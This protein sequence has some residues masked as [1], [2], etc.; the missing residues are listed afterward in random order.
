MLYS[1]G[2]YLASSIG[3]DR[4]KLYLQPRLDPVRY[5]ANIGYI[6]S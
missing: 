2:V 6:S 4:L 3:D 1:V 5:I